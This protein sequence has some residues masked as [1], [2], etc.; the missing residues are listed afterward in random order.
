MK[1]K[2]IVGVKKTAK[3]GADAAWITGGRQDPR[4]WERKVTTFASTDLRICQYKNEE[5]DEIFGGR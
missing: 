5:R 1:T 2:Q 3:A 4:G